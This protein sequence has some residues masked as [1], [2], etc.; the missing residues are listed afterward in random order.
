M[1][2]TQELNKKLGLA[3]DIHA[4]IHIFYTPIFHVWIPYFHCTTSID[5][6]L[7]HEALRL[8]KVQCWI[9]EDVL[10]ANCHGHMAILR[11]VSQ[12]CIRINYW[13]CVP[14]AR[15]V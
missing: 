11:D 14:H 8:A 15:A 3:L 6:H 5:P 2:D 1:G 9:G 7:G 4:V 12:F 10:M 13:L